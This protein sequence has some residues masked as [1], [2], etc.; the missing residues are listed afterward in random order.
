MAFELQ[1]LVTELATFLLLG[2]GAVVLR[3]QR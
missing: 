2:L 3:K 1:G